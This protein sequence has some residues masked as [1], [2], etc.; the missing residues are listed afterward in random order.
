MGP[1]R[2]A[3][4]PGPCAAKLYASCLVEVP[5]PQA[6]RRVHPQS[7]L[8]DLRALPTSTL[9]KLWGG[10]ARELWTTISP[11][12]SPSMT[13]TSSVSIRA[14]WAF[15][16]EY[17]FLPLSCHVRPGLGKRKSREV[18]GTFTAELWP[19]P[20]LT[21]LADVNLQV[22]HWL[23]EVANRAA[24]IAK[25]ADSGRTLSPEAPAIFCGHHARLSRH[26]GRSGYSKE[27]APMAF[28]G[29]HYC[30]PPR[31]VGYWAHRK[32]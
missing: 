7:E 5:Q 20:Y 28:D 25:P 16:R 8:R 13:A 26:R 4:V 18:A 30:V 14:S 21:D 6:L 31:Y 27:S 2:R 17:N 3:V 12:P 29:N 22:R 23:D 24:T 1:L 32:G 19:L 10:V 11:P 15:A 9:S